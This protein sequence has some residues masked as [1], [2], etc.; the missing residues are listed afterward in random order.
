MP[1]DDKDARRAKARAAQALKVAV[2]CMAKQNTD[3]PTAVTLYSAYVTATYPNSKPATIAA[4]NAAF[5][6]PGQNL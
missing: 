6:C 2:D 3:C 5:K 4:I 1:T